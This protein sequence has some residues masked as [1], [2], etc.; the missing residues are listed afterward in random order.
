[1]TKRLCQANADLKGLWQFLLPETPFPS[2]GTSE[3][4]DA[5]LLDETQG[6]NETHKDA[7]RRDMRARRSWQID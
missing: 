2:C 5:E 7:T 6:A 4:A 3:N 1:M